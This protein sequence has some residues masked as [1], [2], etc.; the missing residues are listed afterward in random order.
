[1][2][3]SQLIRLGVDVRKEYLHDQLTSVIDSNL[4][5][6]DLEVNNI[7]IHL[8]RNEAIVYHI[9]DKSI[10]ISCPLD[11]ALKRPSGLFTVEGEGKLIIK[12]RTRIGFGHNTIVAH[13]ELIDHSWIER[14]VLQ[15]G[16]L[17]MPVSTLANML[18][19][20]SAT[21]I[22]GKIDSAIKDNI[23]PNNLLDDFFFNRIEDFN[24]LPHNPI[25]L[26][27][28]VEGIMIR[29]FDDSEDLIHISAYIQGHLIATSGDP[30][31]VDRKYPNINWLDERVETHQ[32]RQNIILSYDQIRSL[33]SSFLLSQDFGGSNIDISRLDVEYNGDLIL[34]SDIVK[35]IS[36]TLVMTGKPIYLAESD[37][38]MLENM[39]ITSK[40]KS[41]FFQL[42]SPM[43]ESMVKSKIT[44]AFPIKVN[45]LL[46]NALQ[47]QIYQ[48]NERSELITIQMDGIEIDSGFFDEKGLNM[49]IRLLE[50]AVNLYLT[51][52]K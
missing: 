35:P 22:T 2:N 21:M 45:E 1:M 38:L 23:R 29:P 25:V 15:L 6:L 10:I 48:V 7:K 26:L 46:W 20:H 49:S 9:E 28:E 27:P 47:S 11:I 39:R 24:K 19:D 3:S 37:E 5:V 30:E 14:P 43:T 32:L 13:S 12:I 50:P 16:S 17:N 40:A 42:V 44:E 34:T 18:I 41:L 4:E 31:I 51:E 36:M 52:L 8:E 33:I